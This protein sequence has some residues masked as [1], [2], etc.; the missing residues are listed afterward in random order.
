MYPKSTLSLGWSVGP[1]SMDKNNYYDWGMITAMHDI[2]ESHHIDQPLTFP[3]N[4]AYLRQS[5]YPLLW[6]CEMTGSS[7]TVYSKDSDTISVDDLLFMRSYLSHSK[8]YFDLPQELHDSFIEQMQEDP[9]IEK[10]PTMFSSDIWS[11][12]KSDI[13]ESVYMGTEAVV[14]QNALLVSKAAM[15][16]GDNTLTLK[17]LL[18]FLRHS[19]T[20]HKKEDFDLDFELFLRVT[21]GS[22]PS[23]LSG[24]R[25]KITS[26]GEISISSQ[27]IPGIDQAVVENFGHVAECFSFTIEDNIRAQTINLKVSVMS[28]CQSTTQQILDEKSVAFNRKGIQ[29]DGVYIAL[30]T[31]GDDGFVVLNQFIIET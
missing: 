1:A 25:C 10:E 17:G 3:V 18:T 31:S 21:Q 12:I 2:L 8:L 9:Q 5:L 7:L 13:G 19:E 24:I 15:H 26:V 27:G 4:A 30:K 23:V 20:K 16:S 14:I 28:G 11:V 29:L 6:L 22:N